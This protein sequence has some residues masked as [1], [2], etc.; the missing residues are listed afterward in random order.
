LIKEKGYR[1]GFFPLLIQKKEE[2]D[3]SINKKKKKCGFPNNRF[4]TNQN[5]AKIITKG[6]K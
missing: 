6:R 2:V 3:D 4:K 5:S 1:E